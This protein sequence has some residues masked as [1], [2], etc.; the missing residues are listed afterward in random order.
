MLQ[1]VP[2]LQERLENQR[3]SQ[4]KSRRS[5]E[6]RNGVY[7]P[8]ALRLHTRRLQSTREDGAGQ[9]AGDVVVLWWQPEDM[10]AGRWRLLQIAGNCLSNASCGTFFGS[11]ER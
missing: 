6:R 8:P 10:P 11:S 1:T 7:M 4:R 3:V 2:F 5:P 9:H